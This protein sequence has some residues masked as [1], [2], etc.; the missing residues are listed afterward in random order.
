MSKWHAGRIAAKPLLGVSKHR[1]WMISV[2]W[3]IERTGV[4]PGYVGLI[5]DSWPIALLL[6]VWLKVMKTSYMLT[7]MLL[8]ANLA[9]TK[10][11]KNP[12]K[13]LKPWHMGT[14]LRVLSK[15]YP[16]NYN[17]N[18]RGFRCFSK[19]FAWFGRFSSSFS[20]GRVKSVGHLMYLV[21]CS[22]QPQG[23]Q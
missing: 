21:M 6:V 20:I 9:N 1:D 8:V 2:L 17:T 12:E 19:I 13:W 22:V 5:S 23:A 18:V 10:W 11:C 4:Q 14:H 16:M 3:S 7:V 15:S